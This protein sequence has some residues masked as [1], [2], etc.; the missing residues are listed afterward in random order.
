MTRHPRLLV[1]LQ[2]GG[3]AARRERHDEGQ[4]GSGWAR[5]WWLQHGDHAPLGPVGAEARPGGLVWRACLHSQAQA[6]SRELNGTLQRPRRCAA[7]GCPVLNHQ[8][9]GHPRSG[10]VPDTRR[11]VFLLVL[12][13]YLSTGVVYAPDV[14]HGWATALLGRPQHVRETAESGPCDCAWLPLLREHQHAQAWG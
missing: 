8:R 11:T 12:M 6:A 1:S 13:H 7:A 14:T 5:A 10:V 3:C 4:P 2:R 9:L